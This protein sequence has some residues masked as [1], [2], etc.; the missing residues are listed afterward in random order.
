MQALRMLASQP[1]NLCRPSLSK[2]RDLLFSRIVE[3]EALKDSGLTEDEFFMSGDFQSDSETL[4]NV[5]P[6]IK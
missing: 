4:L 3:R 6:E 1:H 5:V 2:L